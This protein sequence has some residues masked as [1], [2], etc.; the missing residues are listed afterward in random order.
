MRRLVTSLL[1]L[2]GGC[3][4]V[5]TTPQLVGCSD[6]L[7]CD[8][9]GSSATLTAESDSQTDGVSDENPG[10]EVADDALPVDPADTDA[11]TDEEQDQSAD[12]L[13]EDDAPGQDEGP[14]PPP[15][16]DPPTITPDQPEGTLP[17]PYVPDPYA[18]PPEWGDLYGD[19][20]DDPD[21][22]PFDDPFS[23]RTRETGTFFAAGEGGMDYGHSDPAAATAQ[24]PLTF[25]T[26]YLPD[27]LSLYLDGLTLG[28]LG[29]DYGDPFTEA[30]PIAPRDSISYLEQI[31]RDSGVSDSLCRR[32]Y[33]Q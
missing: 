20:F 29:D 28:L 32:L 23:E 22:E 24:P 17:N 5:P 8:L 14:F 1:L 33:G 31:C 10:G 25:D 15:Y 7:D 9:D 11:L 19:L 2:I 30:G 12:D 27:L 21:Y 6:G 18:L 4:A 26:A 13:V 3:G 16:D